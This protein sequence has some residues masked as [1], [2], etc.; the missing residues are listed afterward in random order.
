MALLFNFDGKVYGSDEA[1]MLKEMY[2]EEFSL[3][4]FDDFI[5]NIIV[6]F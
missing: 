5:N 2:K 6:Y 1:R 3:G 4:T